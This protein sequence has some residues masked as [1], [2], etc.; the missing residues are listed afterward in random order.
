MTSQRRAPAR[1]TLGGRYANVRRSA[2]TTAA[3]C[4]AVLAISAICRHADAA[5]A[6]S[7]TV[8]AAGDR[9]SQVLAGQQVGIPQFTCC[10]VAQTIHALLD[11]SLNLC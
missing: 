5:A 4:L 3:A 7:V 6:A 2:A 8:E 9:I 10:I 11:F 1:L